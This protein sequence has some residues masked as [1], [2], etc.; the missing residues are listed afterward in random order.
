M[1]IAGQH[2]VGFSWRSV[3]FSTGQIVPTN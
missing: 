2:L 3:E 1:G